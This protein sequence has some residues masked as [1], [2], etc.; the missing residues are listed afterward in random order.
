MLTNTNES[1]NINKPYI[2]LSEGL[3]NIEVVYWDQG[4]DAS[5]NLTYKLD[6]DSSW[7]AFNST[8]LALFQDGEGFEPKLGTL[9]DLVRG[10]DGKWYIQSGVDYSAGS[11]SDQITGT[12][13]KDIIHGNSGNDTL[14][15]GGNND[16]LYGGLGDDILVGGDGDDMLFGGAGNDTLTGGAGNDTYVWRSG[17]QG[18]STLPAIDHVAKFDKA[19]DVIDISDLLDHDG[20]KSSDV[21]E[22]YL[23]ISKTSDGSVSLISMTQMQAVAR[24]PASSVLQSIVL[25]GVSY[26]DLTGSSLVVVP[27]MYW[28]ICFP[29]TC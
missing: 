24:R 15:G 8:N 7:K 23:S 11:G 25:D 4:G 9:D 16:E 17:E 2:E 29:T 21:L 10:S 6:T 12:D 19:Q 18:S 22:N 1:S 13:G 28:T 27:P 14:A 26:S 20:S 3:H 5:F